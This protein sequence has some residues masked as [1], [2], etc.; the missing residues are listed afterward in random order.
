M[1][2]ELCHATCTQFAVEDN[3]ETER[4]RGVSQNVYCGSFF[5]QACP[6][7]T[8]LFEEFDRRAYTPPATPP[9]PMSPLGS[10]L[11]VTVHRQ[12]IG[13]LYARGLVAGESTGSC[14]D[15]ELEFDVQSPH[16]CSSSGSSASAQG[17]VSMNPWIG[18]QIAGTDEPGRTVSYVMLHGLSVRDD[19]QPSAPRN[20]T[21]F[22]VFTSDDIAKFGEPCATFGGKGAPDAAAPAPQYSPTQQLP[23]KASGVRVIFVRAY[24]AGLTLQIGEV[25]IYGEKSHSSSAPASA[26]LSSVPSTDHRRLESVADAA[27]ERCSRIR[28]QFRP[29]FPN[30]DGSPRH[31]GA[32]T[33]ELLCGRFYGHSLTTDASDIHLCHWDSRRGN[34]RCRTNET[35]TCPVDSASTEKQKEK[36]KQKKNQQQPENST[37]GHSTEHEPQ[38]MHGL[39]RSLMLDMTRRVCEAHGIDN[40]LAHSQRVQAGA[41]WPLLKQSDSNRSCYDCRTAKPSDCDAFFLTVYGTNAGTGEEEAH[42]YAYEDGSPARRKLEEQ[43]GEHMDRV[44]CMRMRSDPTQKEHCHRKW[45]SHIVQSQNAQRVGHIMRRLHEANHPVASEL[46]PQHHVGIDVLAPQTHSVPECRQASPFGK[47]HDQSP[48]DAEC[49]LRSALGHVA[50]KH[51]MSRGAMDSLFKNAGFTTVDLLHRMAK[52]LGLE[53]EGKEHRSSHADG[54]ATATDGVP[55]FMQHDA[56]R[57]RAADE[58]VAADTAFRQKG[59]SADGQR[60][61]RVLQAEAKQSGETPVSWQELDPFTSVMRTML[62]LDQKASG[63]AHPRDAMRVASESASAWAAR[64]ADY[65]SRIQRASS[66]QR[67]RQQQESELAGTVESDTAMFD[68]D[69]LARLASFVVS[70][71][72]SV[73]GRTVGM[74]HSANEALLKM[75]NFSSTVRRMLRESKSTSHTDEGSSKRASRSSLHSFMH[76]IFADTSPEQ[77][78]A[79]VARHE[80][81]RRRLDPVN[82]SKTSKSAFREPK[83]YFVD[84]LPDWHVKKY[85]W[86][87][88]VVDWRSAW[89]QAQLIVSADELKMHWW[90]DSADEE[91]P[92]PGDALSGFALFDAKTPPTAV[93]RALRVLAAAANR[94]P[95]AWELD[96]NGN[97]IDRA[98][99][100]RLTAGGPAT[101]TAGSPMPKSREQKT[102]S[103]RLALLLTYRGSDSKI[104]RLGETTS[105]YVMRVPYAAGSLVSPVTYVLGPIGSLA[106][107]LH[108]ALQGAGVEYDPP[109]DDFGGF[110]T[111]VGHYIVFNFFLCYL[112]APP[113]SSSAAL[114]S[115]DR[116][117]GDGDFG[118]GTSVRTLHSDHMCF[119][120]IPFRPMNMPTFGV[121]FNTTGIV[122]K[123]LEYS[124]SCDTQSVQSAMSTLDSI[125]ISLTT[126]HYT[127]VA[128]FLRPAEAVDALRAYAASAVS[129]NTPSESA[130]HLVCGLTLSGGIMY[131][132]ML[133]PLVI[134]LFMFAPL[135]FAIFLCCTST[136]TCAISCVREGSKTSGNDRYAPIEIVGSGSPAGFLADTHFAPES[137]RF[138]YKGSAVDEVNEETSAL[139]ERIRDRPVSFR[140]T[141]I[142]RT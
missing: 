14:Y 2:L 114:G 118:D 120:A 99:R 64:G 137:K 110:L 84:E 130:A 42:R 20:A 95:A 22:D 41:L 128:L 44:C 16:V 71:D 97:R 140:N 90:S 121:Q 17:F 117:D 116:D 13:G 125:G 15:G 112:Y 72:G 115:Y 4:G 8:A 46:E 113:R 40:K 124:K 7:D 65:V 1:D 108:S 119:P 139:I 53:R 5:A 34:G 60:Q 31:C 93:G 131:T 103:E 126:T 51:G 105:G 56:G 74:A 27:G 35:H 11:Q 106:G 82:R 58:R 134:L 129:S 123:D 92:V 75:R 104:R 37:A 12:L 6:F 30:N 63:A 85:G 66:G 70:A 21:H 77:D 39:L 111:A 76:D 73:V 133:L 96:G 10:L 26:T 91:K 83:R 28:A 52:S 87:A 50:T 69:S 101:P 61:H 89:Q 59:Q 68:D 29:L 32:L 18:V 25:Q 141:R 81:H 102:F 43:I 78:S 67:Q 80:R 23:C 54:T 86:V 24:G 88:G 79:A 138:Y 55:S 36:V 57:A 48:T 19:L 62:S 136:M 45:C 127:P 109:E 9:P 100:R 49:M 94:K 135:V 3:A 142:K 122:W 47:R 98:V 33:D 107:N 132:L 38:T